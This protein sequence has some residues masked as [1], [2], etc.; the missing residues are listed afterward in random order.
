MQDRPVL[1]HYHI[2]KNAGCSVDE[3][4]RASYGEAWAEFEGSHAHDIQ[5]SEQLAKFLCAK[6]HLR[7]VSSHLARPPLPWRE[8]L[9]VV[10]LR[11]PLL[12]ARSV[13][14]F[15]R[16]D[17]TQPFSQP[18]RDNDFAGYIRWALR[19]ERG[20]IVVRNYQ[21]IHLSSASWRCADILSTEA[22]SDDLDGA[23]DLLSGWGAVGI[24]EAFA[25][26]TRVFQACY[27][28][29]LPELKF[30]DIRV[31]ATVA[32]LTSVE[33]QIES[34]RERLGATLFADFMAANELD[35]ALYGHAKRI[36]DNAAA[37]VRETFKAEV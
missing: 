5:S 24:V 13:Y 33:D 29:S 34:C 6:P 28:R 3:S 4:L 21:V 25:R 19:R 18:A 36:L 20:S 27:G 14:E 17:S 12:R 23:R 9:P 32:A 16:R 10:F 11:H 7:A 22:V 37:N 26:S 30:R 35:L 8:C 1:I 15:T 31:N 2:F